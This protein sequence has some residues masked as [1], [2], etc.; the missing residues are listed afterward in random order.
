[1]CFYPRMFSSSGQLSGWDGICGEQLMQ[2]LGGGWVLPFLLVCYQI[3]SSSM[4][5]AVRASCYKLIT[6]SFV[7][8]E[9]ESKES[10]DYKNEVF[11]WVTAGRELTSFPSP[12]KRRQLSAFPT[13]VSNGDGGWLPL[14]SS[15]SSVLLM[16]FCGEIRSIWKFKTESSYSGQQL[17]PESL[18]LCCYITSHVHW[19]LRA[20]HGPRREPYPVWMYEARN[21]AEFPR[22]SHLRRGVPLRAV[23]KCH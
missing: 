13:E 17:S 19:L 7:G 12:R 16:G 9:M 22:A 18:L 14:P 1:M 11:F 2:S 3:S 23:K 5:L 21:K 15:G 8:F 4:P 10:L 6:Y 20:A